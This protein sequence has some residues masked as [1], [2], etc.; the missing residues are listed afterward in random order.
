MKELQKSLTLKSRELEDK[1][2]AA[3]AKLKEMLAD[4]QKAEKEK[5]LSEQ[6]QKELS[7]QLQEIG[8]KRSE[9]EKDLSQV[10]PAVDEAKQAVQGIRKNQLVEVCFLTTKRPWIRCVPWRRL[11]VS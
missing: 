8:T 3:N 6:L 9:V 11:R 10:E 4:Q 2:T 7:V 5:T 1:K